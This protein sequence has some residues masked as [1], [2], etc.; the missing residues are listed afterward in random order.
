MADYAVLIQSLKTQYTGIF[1]V[2]AFGGRYVKSYNLPQ[3][4][5]HAYMYDQTSY[6]NSSTLHVSL[7]VTVCSYG[8]MLTAWL[9]FKYPNL[10][11]GGLAASAP[12]FYTEDIL[13]RTAFSRK[14]TEVNNTSDISCLLAW[15]L[16]HLHVI[17]MDIG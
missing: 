1:K 17:C 10:V 3:V 16:Q 14:V 11:D 12:I 6:T 4:N 5:S 2:I 8:G 15:L 9:R 13:P 7:V